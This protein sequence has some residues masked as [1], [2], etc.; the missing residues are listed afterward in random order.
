M[1]HIDLYQTLTVQNRTLFI[2]IM[3]KFE[4]ELKS[5]HETVLPKTL[6]IFDTMFSVYYEYHRTNR[7][8]ERHTIKFS[9]TYCNTKRILV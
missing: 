3:Y 1:E 4:I 2:A 6:N 8:D 9:N 7:S 5:T